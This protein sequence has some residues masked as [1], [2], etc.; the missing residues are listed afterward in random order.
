MLYFALRYLPSVMS[1]SKLITFGVALPLAGLLLLMCSDAEEIPHQERSP[2]ASVGPPVDRLQIPPQRHLRS[3]QHQLP[4]LRSVAQEEVEPD[5]LVQFHDVVF[6]SDASVTAAVKKKAGGKRHKVSGTPDV[7]EPLNDA[8]CSG[9]GA[10]LHCTASAVPGYIPS[11]KY[12]MLLQEGGLGRATCQRCHL[13]T[14][15]HKVLSIQM[16]SDQYRD[17]LQ[18]VRPLKGLVLLII[19]LLDVP[20]SIIPDL[21]KLVGTN[22]NIIVLGNKIDLLPADSPNYLQ[23]IK[24]Q[25]SQ[26]CRETSFGVQVTDI[27]LISAKTGYGIE[28]LVSSLQRSWKYK[29]DVYLVGSA[30]AGKSTLFN[31]LLESDYC[32]S[33]ASTL[34]HKATISPLPGEHATCRSHHILRSSAQ[35][36]L[37]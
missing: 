25:L 12:K 33:K 21:P 36:K 10:V 28:G 26:Y 5:S 34:I 15:H 2:V 8:C 19:D 27:H 7:D 6:R 37:Y 23:R 18:Q 17:V 13:L 29:G 3:L 30:N 4:M 32:K 20:D 22:K 9:C 1:D 35:N 14:H 16:T 11:E 24:R 31:T